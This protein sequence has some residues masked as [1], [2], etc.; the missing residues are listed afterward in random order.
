MQIRAHRQRFDDNVDL[1]TELRT[2]GLCVCRS[3]VSLCVMAAAGVTPDLRI[4]FAGTH[5]FDSMSNFPHFHG[6]SPSAS[7]GRGFLR[8]MGFE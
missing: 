2:G 8:K 6:K 7:S 5:T 3:P 4:E 1:V